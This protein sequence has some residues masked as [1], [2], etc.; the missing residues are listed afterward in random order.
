MRP[1]GIGLLDMGS[2]AEPGRSE[3]FFC[4]FWSPGSLF[5]YIIEG[6]QLQKSIGLAAR[7]VALSPLGGG[8][9]IT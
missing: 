1:K 6:K 3:R 4:T 2:G 9:E 7:E 5:P 8:A